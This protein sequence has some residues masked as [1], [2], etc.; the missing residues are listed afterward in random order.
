M[1]ATSRATG[2]HV[3]EVAN[4]VTAYRISLEVAWLNFRENRPS[5]QQAT[6]IESALKAEARLRTIVFRSRSALNA[7]ELA[8]V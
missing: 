1:E 8:C 6:L 2:A 3:H 4:L 7:E 5:L